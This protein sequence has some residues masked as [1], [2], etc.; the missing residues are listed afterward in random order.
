MLTLRSQAWRI[1]GLTGEY[2]L[3]GETPPT[4]PRESLCACPLIGD[5]AYLLCPPDLFFEDTRLP[6]CLAFCRLARRIYS[7]SGVGQL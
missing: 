7:D 3:I 1:S 2:W 4:P 6:Y 5:E